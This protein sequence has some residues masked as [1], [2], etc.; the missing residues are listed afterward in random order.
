[1]TPD[2]RTPF[3]LPGS[4]S[5]AGLAWERIVRA[6]EALL[7]LVRRLEARWVTSLMRSLTQLGEVGSWLILALVLSAVGGAAEEL[8]VLLVSGACS[9]LVASQ[10]LKRTIR[11]HRPT[12]GITG[13]AA[14][15]ENP[16]AFSF[17]SGHTAVAFGVAACLA[18]SGEALEWVMFPLAGGIGLSRVYLGAHYPLDVAAGALVGCGSGLLA[19]GVLDGSLLLLVDTGLTIAGF[20][21]P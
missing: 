3:T 16:D 11:R 19:R 1:M 12:R 15:V 2:T 9:A 10:V 6:D 13:F 18:G 21:L 17:P 5:Y 14:L 4:V 7:L 8:A 20:G